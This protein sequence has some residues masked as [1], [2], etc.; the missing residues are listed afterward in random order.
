M[1]CVLP[2]E[3]EVLASFSLSPVSYTHLDVYKRQGVSYVGSFTWGDNT[4]GFVFADK[5]GNNPKFVAECIS[6]ES[7][8]TVGLSHQSRYDNNCSMTEQY[9]VGTGAGETSW[10][11]V[12]GNSY[13][14]NMTGWNDGPTPYGCAN[15]QDNLTIITSINGFSYRADDFKD[16]INLSLIH[17]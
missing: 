5:L 10:A 13:Y 7:G 16:E 12:M 17:I 3:P 1:S 8:H 4:P 6:H 15:T 11:P 9:N 14:R 2:G